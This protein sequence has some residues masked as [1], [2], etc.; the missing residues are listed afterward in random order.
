MDSVRVQR[1]PPPE[2]GYL[3]VMSAELGRARVDSE[4][5]WLPKKSRLSL[6][7]WRAQPPRIHS[8]PE[9]NRT[10][11][12]L[13]VTAVRGDRA[14]GKRDLRKAKRPASL[15][16]AGRNASQGCLSTMPRKKST[17]FLAMVVESLSLRKCR[18]RTHP[19]SSRP[20]AVIRG[21]SQM[22]APSPKRTKENHLGQ[23]QEVCYQC[24]TKKGRR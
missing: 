12:G 9:R 7:N 13:T 23:Q 3:F 20:G 4:P 22:A 24:P 15:P 11:N 6:A 2:G 18:A 14:S 17:H 19:C 16:A 5:R 10:I 1:N 8:A 21:S